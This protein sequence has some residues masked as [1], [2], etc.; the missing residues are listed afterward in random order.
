M[1][2]MKATILCVDDE[3]VNLKLYDAF[4]LPQGYATLH[5]AGGARALEIIDEQKVDLVLL[6]VMMPELNGYDV[7]RRIKENPAHAGL[8]VILITSLSYKKERIRGIEAG[9]EE[10]VTK[11]IDQDEVL[12]RIRMLL[13]V[14][15][16]NERLGRSVASVAELTR[17]AKESAEG[18]DP[19]EF[20]LMPQVDRLMGGV[21]RQG[22]DD[23]DRPQ[24]MIAGI[25]AHAGWTWRYYESPFKELVRHELEPGGER[26]LPLPGPG[27]SLSFQARR[28]EF[29][30]RGLDGFVARLEEQPRL[31]ARLRD[32]LAFLSDGLCVLAANFD[33][34]VRDDDATIL[35]ILAA[36]IISLQ[37]LDELARR[38]EEDAVRTVGALLRAAA[39]HGEEDESHP[40]RVGEY[41]ALLARR[42]G[43]G[44]RF[45]AAIRL[46]AQ[47]HD[48]G[49][50]GIPLDLL[51][52]KGSPD[53]QEWDAI[54]AHARL[55]AEIIGD[56]PQ[57]AM[58]RVIALGHH[59]N[60]DGSGYP[61]WLQG[62]RI[63]VA[64]RIVALAD[65]YDALRLARA[66]KPAMD[67][68]SAC[69][70]ILR[71]SERVRPEHFD[72]QVIAAFR[73]LAP[74][75]AEIF[76]RQQAPAGER[77]AG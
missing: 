48:V 42:L 17:F 71:G 51:A 55:G 3:P 50:L 61:N 77:R 59:E 68:S 15:D 26:L 30:S 49:N 27:H 18:F 52:K 10:F 14:K 67:H 39:L 45:A 46:Q 40:R 43:L 32:V 13:R 72:P 75:F 29:A 44:E 38:I 76:E 66:Y 33:R 12:A 31:A 1:S 74:R 22:R 47:L 63:P 6:D 58:A 28:G 11:P 65:R 57:L 23:P 53:F 4:L 21:I 5:A 56:H 9:A 34:D 7:C 19:A 2:A 60:W 54:R 8:P 24:V 64:A 36:E 20:E 70:V 62:E 73:E 25:R 41:S 35:D 37:R 69:E 16:L